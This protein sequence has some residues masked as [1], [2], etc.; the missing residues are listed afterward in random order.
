MLQTLSAKLWA[1][2][3]LTL[4]IAAGAMRLQR[5]QARTE[6]AE[7][8][9]QVAQATQQA[10]AQARALETAKRHQA[11]RI[12]HEDQTKAQAAQHAA[13]A[14]ARAADSL[15]DG[16]ASLDAGPAPTDPTTAHH[17]EQARTARELLAT[18]ADRYTGVAADADRLAIQV[19]G[20]QAF[21]R[22]VCGAPTAND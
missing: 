15:H 22:D 8:R 12:A 20:L 14:A 10:E 5:D 13:D 3:I 6:L 19:T 11:D 9:A 17:A 2:L 4:L 18:C 21:A 16:I 7:A 1:T